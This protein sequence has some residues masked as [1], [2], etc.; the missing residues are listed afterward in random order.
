[1]DEEDDLGEDA[2]KDR[3]ELIKSKSRWWGTLVHVRLS[4][5]ML[6]V[7]E[8]ERNIGGNV[9]MLQNTKPNDCFFPVHLLANMLL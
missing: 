9:D 4:E 6:L 5:L 7:L 8:E 3:H 2:E 1:V